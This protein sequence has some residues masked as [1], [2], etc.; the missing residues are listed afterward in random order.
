MQRTIGDQAANLFGK[1]FAN[2]LAGEQ[3]E[4]L[5]QDLVA[6]ID[7]LSHQLGP[8]RD[9]GPHQLPIQ[10]LDRDLTV[11]AGADDLGQTAGIVGV[12]LVELE[13]QRRLGVAGIETDHRQTKRG[14]AVAAYF[15]ESA[16][17]FRFKPP[18]VSVILP[19]LLMGLVGERR[20]DPWFSPYAGIAGRAKRHDDDEGSAA[21]WSAARTRRMDSPVSSIRSAR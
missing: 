10:A 8:R 16:L 17:A 1:G 18:T 20:R 21:L 4:R 9:Q 2:S 3:A 7:P 13:L 14:Q 5:E 15:G 11:P 12:A 19:T 6:E